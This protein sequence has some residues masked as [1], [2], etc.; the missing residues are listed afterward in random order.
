M[1]VIQPTTVD[2]L[3]KG[4]SVTDSGCWEWVRNRRNNY[5]RMS[6]DGRL[7]ATHRLA[8]AIW[9][10][11]DL[12]NPKVFVC[13]SCDN[14]PCFNPDHLFLGDAFVNMRDASTKGRLAGVRPMRRTK[15]P[16]I[17]PC[18]TCGQEYMPDGDHRGRSVVCS[19]RCLAALRS[20]LRAGKGRALS[21]WQVDQARRLIATGATYKQ[22]GELMGVSG[23]SIHRNLNGRAA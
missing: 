11:L 4:R 17:K 19:A 18:A 20:V 16:R 3:L 14:P 9:L 13:H 23:S 2:R 22:V 5:G 12:S 10:G 15:Y 8:A 21:D 6:V 1:T 7:Y